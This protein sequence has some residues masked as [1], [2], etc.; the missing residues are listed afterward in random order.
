[1]INDSDF[2]PNRK[3]ENPPHAEKAEELA[4]KAIKQ[5]YSPNEAGDILEESPRVDHSLEKDELDETGSQE[6][7]E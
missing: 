1:M 2:Q 3:G 5:S 7:G 4:K 6:A